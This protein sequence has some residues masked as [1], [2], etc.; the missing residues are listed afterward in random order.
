MRDL[1]EL[2]VEVLP[3]ARGEEAESLE[4]AQHVRVADRSEVEVRPPWRVAAGT[5]NPVALPRVS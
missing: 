5:L 1:G 2:V 3:N 4:Q